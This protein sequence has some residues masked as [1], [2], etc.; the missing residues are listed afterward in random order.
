MRDEGTRDEGT[1]EGRRDAGMSEERG[2]S[3]RGSEL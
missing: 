2:T 3:C 1:S